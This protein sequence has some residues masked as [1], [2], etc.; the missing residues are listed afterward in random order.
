MT[1]NSQHVIRRAAAMIALASILTFAG[2]ATIAGH[3]LAASQSVSFEISDPE[4]GFSAAIATD[5]AWNSEQ[6][7][8]TGDVATVAYTLSPASGSATIAVPLSLLGLGQ[9]Q[10]VT[11]PLP[12][13]PLGSIFISLTQSLA[14]IPS[15]VAS[16]NLVLQA[17]IRM[18]RI[19]WTSDSIDMLTDINDLVWTSWGSKS[20]SLLTSESV[21]ATVRA[22]LEYTL[23]VG[24]QATVLTGSMVLIPTTPV[25]GVSG[26]PE[27]ATSLSVSDDSTLLLTAGIGAAVGGAAIVAAFFILRRRSRKGKAEGPGDGQNA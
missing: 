11:V 18:A 17:S 16:V 20:V 9:D 15:N 1:P 3:A 5:V 4:I 6:S 24:V 23:S 2:Q 13:T 12:E 10:T 8:E 21:D 14:G 19:A 26:T 27:L 7:V 22:T 25:S